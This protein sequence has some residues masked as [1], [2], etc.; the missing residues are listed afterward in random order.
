MS[1]LLIGLWWGTNLMAK[2]DQ[3]VHGGKERGRQGEWGEGVREREGRREYL[4]TLT[5]SGPLALSR[6]LVSYTGMRLGPLD[7]ISS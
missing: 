1:K 3:S 4:F 5:L 2:E 7:T 6:A